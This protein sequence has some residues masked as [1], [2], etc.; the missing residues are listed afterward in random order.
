VHAH[1]AVGL[2]VLVLQA[3]DESILRRERTFSLVQL[4]KCGRIFDSDAF[5][6]VVLDGIDQDGPVGGELEPMPARRLFRHEGAAALMA[7]QQSFLAQDI[8]GL[9]DRD[10]RHL[11][12]ALEL[13][14]RGYLLARPPLLSFDALAHDR[15]NLDVER[16][17]AAVVGLQELGHGS[18]HQA[19]GQ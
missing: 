17:P 15:C 10:P 8:D 9:T 7:M 4:G 14:Q 13:N 11:E 1:D 3:P 18:F 16:N 19:V 6:Y 12:L 5:R 2:A